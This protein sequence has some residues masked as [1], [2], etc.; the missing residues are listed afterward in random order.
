MFT[1]CDSYS[2]SYQKKT[3]DNNLQNKHARL[4][5]NVYKVT[6]YVTAE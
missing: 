3:N 5:A 2:Y 6:I 1:L 4:D